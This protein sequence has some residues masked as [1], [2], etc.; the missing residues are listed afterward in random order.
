META[1]RDIRYAF[2]VL[3][4]S[5]GFTVVS[6]LTLALGIVG[7][8]FVF[9]AYNATVWQPLPA[10]DPERLV[11]FQR[12]YHK[13]GGD[14]TK[15]SMLDY[16]RMS[17]RSPAFSG[18]VGEGLY[19]TVLAQ[20]PDLDTGRVSESRQALLKVVSENY[21]SVLGV[22]ALLGNVFHATDTGS[23]P[24]A[25]LSDLAWRRRFHSDP[26]VLGKT[27]LVY[28]VG[29][30]VIGVMPP[31]FVG[32]G[33]PP[34]PPDI[35]IPFFAEPIIE[36]ARAARSDTELW[37][38]IFGRLQPGATIAQAQSELTA[39]AQ[40]EEQDLGLEPVTASIVTKPAIYLIDRD[41]PQF[42]T[43]AA[44]LLASFS[45]VLLVACANMANFFMARA[46]ARRREMAVRTALGASKVRLV[47]QLMT[48]G[49]VLGL[50]AGVVATFAAV[51]ICNVVWVEVEQRVIVRF[52]DLYVF[53]FTFA[54]SA[55]V[56]AATCTASVLAGALFS[57][58]GAVQSSRV[59]PVLRG[60]ELFLRPGSRLRLNMR[61]VFITVQITFSVVLLVSAVLLARGMVRGQFSDPGF[62]TRNILNIEFAGLEGAGYDGARVAA[63]ASQLRSQLPL[64]PGVTGLAFATHVP[65]LGIGSADIATSDGAVH[66][67]LDN[68]VSRGFFATLGIP[69]VRGRDFTDSDIAQRAAV[70]II[71]QETAHNLWPGQDPIGKVL[72]FGKT[73]R[74][75]QVIGVAQDVRSVNIGL[76]QPYFLYLPLPPEASLN[77]VIV[78]STGDAKLIVANCLK[79]A[80]LVD[81][82]L[83]SLAVVHTMDEALWFQRLPSMIA[84]MLASVI[85]SLAAILVSVG[86]YGTIS[87]AVARR[88]REIGIRMALGAPRRV[89]V[90]IVVARTIAMV[91]AGAAIGLVLAAAVSHTISA[92][93]FGLQ[94]VLLFGVSPRDPLSF[95]VVTFSL[96]LVALAAAC[97]P[98]TRATK[99][100]PMDALRHE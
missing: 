83:A 68:D 99:I 27:V 50:M 67:A 90:R 23:V 88:T 80:G 72:Q 4:Q 87:Y 41:N 13:G 19:D 53:P 33:N 66:Q 25:V 12:H 98:A 85:G 15:F 94:S 71:S 92:V 58:A 59:E 24:V 26:A 73:K 34:S 79:A 75:M 30:T 40:K 44:L 28:G 16:R 89:V 14:N 31:D 22:G 47:R 60:D 97:R 56:L 69:L 51:W 78:R 82:K 8:T 46:T 35:W 29:L 64:L 37:L 1:L 91:G 45:M 100:D 43:M 76:V 93:P 17:S 32:S 42:R 7:I 95:A 52:S 9:T 21:F 49:I 48:E 86:I 36:P 3:R 38:R 96:L 81:G 2:R 62:N 54:P 70:V 55:R 6:V 11:V 39:V 10:Q 65:L 18:I 61:D 84:T 74:P 63:L 57:L 20:F 77:E 5:P